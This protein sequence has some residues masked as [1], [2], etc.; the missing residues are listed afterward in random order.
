MWLRIAESLGEHIRYRQN[1]CHLDAERR[2]VSTEDAGQYQAERIITTIPWDCCGAAEGLPGELEDGIARLKHTAVEVRYVPEH[3][4]TAAHWIYVPDETLPYHR[5]LVRHNFA[6]GSKG[7]WLET[8][9]ENTAGLHG[10]NFRHLNR[11]AYPLN[12]LEKPKV[13]QTLMAYM[14]KRGIYGLGRWGEHAHYN[15]DVVVERAMRLEEELTGK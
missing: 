6:A 8:R 3:L 2:I 4:E 13:M 5:I 9:Q 15:S 12:T 11:Y 14:Q 1:V 10:D 7:Y